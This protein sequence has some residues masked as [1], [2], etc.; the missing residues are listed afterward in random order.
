MN[1]AD[2]TQ[3]EMLSASGGNIRCWGGGFLLTAGLLTADVG[4]FVVG[5]CLI[6]DYC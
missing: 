4:V 1:V 2:L 3:E 6:A 5:A